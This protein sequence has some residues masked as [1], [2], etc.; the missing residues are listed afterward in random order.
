MFTNAYVDLIVLNVSANEIALFDTGQVVPPFDY[1]P[2]VYCLTVDASN[3]YLYGMGAAYALETNL[4]GSAY[5]GGIVNV[6]GYTGTTLFNVDGITDYF[7]GTITDQPQ[8]VWLTTTLLGAS[9]A[10][11][12]NTHYLYM[13][14]G[15]SYGEGDTFDYLIDPYGSPLSG[16]LV[17]NGID[18]TTLIVDNLLLYEEEPLYRI[19]AIYYSSGPDFNGSMILVGAFD[20]LTTT[21]H[22]Y[23]SLSPPV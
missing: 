4:T 19:N 15:S 12:P 5:G 2:V 9:L 1:Y 18:W 16:L 14:M 23:N 7:F 20:N 17:Y 22:A 11:D 6:F 13:L 21:Y 10:V 8:S 3:G